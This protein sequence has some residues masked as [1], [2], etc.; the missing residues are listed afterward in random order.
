MTALS[1]E[2]ARQGFP[3]SPLINCDERISDRTIGLRPASIMLRRELLDGASVAHSEPVS[4]HYALL[5]EHDGELLPS[6]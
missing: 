5:A 1:P 6:P 2:P 4:R 3:L